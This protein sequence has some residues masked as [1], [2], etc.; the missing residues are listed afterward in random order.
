MYYNF[1]V[2]LLLL[3]FLSLFYIDSTITQRS[4]Q[5]MINKSIFKTK[6]LLETY[7][8]LVCIILYTWVPKELES[9][10]YLL[11]IF[12]VASFLH[13]AYAGIRF[14]ILSPDRRAES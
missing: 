10:T 9:I 8:G 2:H 11:L 4:E 1:V 6:G 13:G 3:F 12:G 14:E 7:L 5:V